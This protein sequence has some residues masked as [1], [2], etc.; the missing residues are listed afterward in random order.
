MGKC[1]SGGKKSGGCGCGQGKN[2]QSNPNWP[3]KNSGKESGK[4]R[5][6]SPSQK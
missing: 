5:G 2:N 3:S 4:G 1:N 6:N